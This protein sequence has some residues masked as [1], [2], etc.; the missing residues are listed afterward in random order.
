MI[1]GVSIIVTTFI[2]EKMSTATLFNVD[3]ITNDLTDEAIV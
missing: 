2:T 3:Q 1:G